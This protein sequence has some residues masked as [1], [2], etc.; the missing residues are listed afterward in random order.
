[1]PGGKNFDMDDKRIYNLDTQDDHKVD[2]DYNDII[3]DLK[4]EYL[5]SK[6]LK[7][8]KNE[9]YFDLRQKII[10]NTESYYDGLSIHR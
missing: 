5:N 8:N 4:K 2:D 9:N 3:K 10:R 1:M 6:F 7:K